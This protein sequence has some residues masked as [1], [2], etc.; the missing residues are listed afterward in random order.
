MAAIVDEQFAE[1]LKKEN[2][3]AKRD[4]AEKLIKAISPTLKAGELD[5][6]F[7]FRG[8]ARDDKYTM[9][10]GIKVKNAADA[11]RTITEVFQEVLKHVPEEER[12]K[13]KLNALKV[14]D[15]NVHRLDFQAQYDEKARKIF[16]E[17][18]LLVAFSDKAFLVAV[19]PEAE[20][21][22]KQAASA[23]PAPAPLVRLELN[24][25]RLYQ[26]GVLSDADR[27][28]AKKILGNGEAGVLS[29]TVQGGPS[30]SVRLDANM[31]LLQ[32]FAEKNKAAFGGE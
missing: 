32:F 17:S 25:A 15:L 7:A 20:A 16:G 12:G 2:D 8:P 11:G 28:L 13:I 9:L 23:S 22:L 4:L 1:A 29:L 18:P 10:L 14:G 31:G 6:G 24:Y 19:G 27:K 26:L 30:V 5:L 21:A 3:E